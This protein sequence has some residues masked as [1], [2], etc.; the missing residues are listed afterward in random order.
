MSEKTKKG[1]YAPLWILIGLC[2]LP[3]IAGT[4]YYQFRDVLPEVGQSNYGRLVQPVKEIRDVQLVLIDGKATDFSE[5]R[6]KWLMLYL[7]EGEC[8][9]ACQKNFYFMRQVRKAMAEDR[10]RINR[11]V[12]LD[13]PELET[14]ALHRVLSEFPGI[15]VANLNQTS[16]QYLYS[17]IDNGS[18]SIFGKIMLIDPLGNYMMEYQSDPDPMEMLKDIKKLLSVSRVG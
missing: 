7:L 17:T 3:Y 1:S 4:L 9:E 13:K 16:R 15:S 5:F 2:T 18:G 12:V 8:H 14:E 6:K 11:L 10:F